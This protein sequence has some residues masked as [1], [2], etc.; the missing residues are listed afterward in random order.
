MK[1]ALNEANVFAVIQE[2]PGIT[3]RK[4]AKHFDV[5][6]MTVHSLADRM[7]ARHQIDRAMITGILSIPKP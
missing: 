4:L 3:Q 2:N 1:H 7:F 5:H 6:F